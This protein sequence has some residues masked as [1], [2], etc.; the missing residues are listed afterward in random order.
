MPTTDEKKKSDDEEVEHE[1]GL[2]RGQQET[3]I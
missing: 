1:R 3:A 2:E